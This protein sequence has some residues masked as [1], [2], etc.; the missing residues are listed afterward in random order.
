MIEGTGDKPL[1]IYKKEHI[2]DPGSLAFHFGTKPQQRFG[3]GPQ[4]CGDVSCVA[5]SLLR[6]PQNRNTSP[7]E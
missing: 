5:A 4:I 1:E 6:S 2:A 7:P 3:E